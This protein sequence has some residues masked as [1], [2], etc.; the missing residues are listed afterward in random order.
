ME[1]RIVSYVVGVFLCFPL[2]VL[3]ILPPLEEEPK[4]KPDVKPAESLVE[5]SI[6]SASLIQRGVKRTCG[7]SQKSVRVKQKQ[8]NAQKQVKK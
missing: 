3:H 1:K 7:N 8:R 2:R 5:K 6:K 4:S